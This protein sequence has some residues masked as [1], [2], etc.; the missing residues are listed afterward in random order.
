MTALSCNRF[1]P[2]S[3]TPVKYGPSELEAIVT[4]RETQRV[5]IRPKIPVV[6]LYLTAN[7]D[8]GGKVRFYENVYNRD[9]RAL[10]ALNGPVIID[11]PDNG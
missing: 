6:I 4:T 7:L 8:P 1:T 9:Q 5:N 3:G 2:D 10:A 11:I